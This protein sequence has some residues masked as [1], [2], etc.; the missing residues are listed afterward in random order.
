MSGN[1]S[2]YKVD[3]KKSAI[4]VVCNECRND[5]YFP[6]AHFESP[7]RIMQWWCDECNQAKDPDEFDEWFIPKYKWPRKKRVA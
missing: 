7:I 6:Y 1:M 5:K 4:R 2:R 3:T